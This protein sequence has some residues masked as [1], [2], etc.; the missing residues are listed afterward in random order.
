ME[1]GLD[2]VRVH[3]EGGLAGQ[4]P[5]Q[6]VLAQGAHAQLAGFPPEIR[7]AGLVIDQVPDLVVGV[8]GSQDRARHLHAELLAEAAAARIRPRVTTF[9]LAEANDALIRL[10]D[11]RIDGSGVLVVAQ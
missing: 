9:P 10:A 3:L 5:A 8:L 1:T 6:A 2:L 11:D 4:H 7:G